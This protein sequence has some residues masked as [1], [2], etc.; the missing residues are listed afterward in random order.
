MK[1]QIRF[2]VSSA[3]GSDRRVTKTFSKVNELATEEQ[4]KDFALAYTSL[5]E[6]SDV[7]VYLIKLEQL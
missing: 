5:T 7:E 6:A 3:D 4:L 1:L 2:R